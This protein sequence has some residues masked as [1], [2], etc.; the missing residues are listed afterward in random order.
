MK[1]TEEKIKRCSLT[2]NISRA[3][4]GGGG[5]I[6]VCWSFEMGTR[7]NDKRVNYS[8]GPTQTKQQIG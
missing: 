7:M 8:H 3:K 6:G 5:G 2:R 1:T 4:W